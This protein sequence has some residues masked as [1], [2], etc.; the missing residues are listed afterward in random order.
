MDREFAILLLTIFDWYILGVFFLLLNIPTPQLL[1][2]S[3]L[4]I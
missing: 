3:V 1:V 2:P 4:N